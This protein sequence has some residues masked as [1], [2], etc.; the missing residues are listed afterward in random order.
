[1]IFFKTFFFFLSLP[2]L[3]NVFLEFV[4]TLLLFYVLLLAPRLVLVL[5]PQPGITPISPALEDEVLTTGPP[6]KAL[7]VLSCLVPCL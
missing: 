3:K 2:F 7:S 5:A 1:M 4:T 6:G